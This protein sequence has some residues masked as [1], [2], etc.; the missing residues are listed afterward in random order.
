MNETPDHHE[1]TWAAD[2]ETLLRVAV[3]ALAP[4]GVAASPVVR[5]EWAGSVSYAVRLSSTQGPIP[6]PPQDVRV[7][8]IPAAGVFMRGPTKPTPLQWMDRLPVDRQVVLLEALEATPH[9]RLFSRRLLAAQEIDPEHPQTV[10]GVGML[11]EAGVLTDEE[12]AAL[13]AP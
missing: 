9:G 1:V 5:V 11:R 10:Q 6:A 13:L 8:G 2:D 3:D 7:E 4:R 12:V